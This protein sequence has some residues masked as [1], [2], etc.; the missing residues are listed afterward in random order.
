MIASEEAKRLV[1]KFKILKTTGGQNQFNTLAKQCALMSVDEKMK[2]MRFAIDK[3]NNHFQG[4]IFAEMITIQLEFQVE[5]K[6]RI[7]EL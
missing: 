1:E 7:E 2:D 3:F 5:V 6:K 4:K